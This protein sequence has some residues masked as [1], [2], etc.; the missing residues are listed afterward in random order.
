M[1]LIL[2]ERDMKLLIQLAKYGCL[3]REIIND[4]YGAKWDKNKTEKGNK[5]PTQIG[6]RKKR[7]TDE[8]YILKT[9]KYAYLGEKGKR[10]LQE[11]GIEEIKSTNGTRF[12]KERLAK[13]SSVLLPLEEVYEITPSWK[14]KTEDDSDKKR[15]F[16]GT[17]KNKIT[18]F[19]YYIF[20]IGGIEGIKIKKEAQEIPEAKRKKKE[21]YIKKIKTEVKALK[22]RDTKILENIIVFAEDKPTMD[23]Y[24]RSAESLVKGE[25]LLLPYGYGIDLLKYFG[26]VDLKKKIM[27][28]LY[29]DN[30]TKANSNIIDYRVGKTNVIVLVNNDVEKFVGLRTYCKGL[31]VHLLADEKN[32]PPGIR[33]ICINGQEA[34]FREEFKELNIEYKTIDDLI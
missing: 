34:S 32:T 17:I 2:Q 6:K 21:S 16:Y 25:Q 5:Y 26:Q 30:Y 19:E 8:G 15:M 22:H 14:I 27:D 11:L 12:T 10:Y 4:I 7:L 3:S 31:S 24:R 18:G 23:L 33:I 13:I 29:G 28:S 1:G 9:N 20:N